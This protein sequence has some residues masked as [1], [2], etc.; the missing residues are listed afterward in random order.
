MKKA[1]NLIIFT[2][3]ID[4]SHFSWLLQVLLVME[5]RVLKKAKKGR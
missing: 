4:D 1:F 3:I 5:A 2:S